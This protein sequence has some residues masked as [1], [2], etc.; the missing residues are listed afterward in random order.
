MTWYAEN[1]SRIRTA[2][3]DL[4]KWF[5][6]N[7]Y[8]GVHL[9]FFFEQQSDE[10]ELKAKD[11]MINT[12]ALPRRQQEAGTSI[13]PRL[14]WQRYNMSPGDRSPLRA[15][16]LE[17]QTIQDPADQKYSTEKR[18]FI[19]PSKNFNWFGF[20][21][22]KYPRDRNHIVFPNNVWMWI[23]KIVSN[24]PNISQ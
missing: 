20:K 21:T 3:S 16:I 6:L 22:P 12:R 11:G 19:R 14:S 24:I 8:R 5:I 17:H 2:G 18:N 15:L 1:T 23:K 7:R 4:K 13:T 10:C 9:N